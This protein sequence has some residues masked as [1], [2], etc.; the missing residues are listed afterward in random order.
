MRWQWSS[1]VLSGRGRHFG[2]GYPALKRRVVVGRP[3]GTRESG[4]GNGSGSMRRRTRSGANKGSLRGFG[5]GRLRIVE[6]LLLTGAR[7]GMIV[8]ELMKRSGKK[9]YDMRFTIYEREGAPWVR[10]VLLGGGQLLFQDKPA[11]TCV[12]R[13]RILGW[14]GGSPKCFRTGNR[15]LLRGH[16]TGNPKQQAARSGVRALPSNV[17]TLISRGLGRKSKNVRKMLIMNGLRCK[18]QVFDFQPVRA[19]KGDFRT[20]FSPLTTLISRGLGRKWQKK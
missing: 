20:H 6:F 14:V 17:T 5:T 19:K 7:R 8:A 18:L 12:G 10:G 11:P 13:L 2:T 4:V 3:G 16:N 9:I 1:G 15:A